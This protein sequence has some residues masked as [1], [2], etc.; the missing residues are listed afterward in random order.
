MSITA[1]IA[2]AGAVL[3]RVDWLKWGLWIAIGV[4]VALLG[5][6]LLFAQAEVRRLQVSLANE[7]RDRAKEQ[8]DAAEAG[9]VATNRIRDLENQ[10]H[11]TGANARDEAEKGKAENERLE[12]QL[13]M[14]A[15]VRAALFAHNDRLQS[16]L[17]DYAAGRRGPA[18]DTLAACQA[19]AGTLGAFLAEGDRLI[20]QLREHGR[21]SL[22]LATAA[23]R[24]HDDRALEVTACLKAWPVN[25][26]AG[27]R[28]PTPTD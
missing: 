28:A 8:G 6:R 26:P 22:G 27:T 9:R 15:A 1:G 19:R 24:A 23:A 16:D 2:A 14:A 18:A 13:R 4:V 5:A 20:T 21:Q 17:N 7:Q 12:A 11:E 25:Q 3:G 10:W